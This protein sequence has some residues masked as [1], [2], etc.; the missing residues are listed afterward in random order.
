VG[1]E[2]DQLSQPIPMIS[3]QG[4]CKSIRNGS[5]TVDILKGLDFAVPQGQFAAVTGASGSGKST[6]LG[7]LAGLDTPSAGNVHLNGIAISYLPEDKLAQV[8]GKTIGFV[9][10]SYQLIPT[11]TALENVLLPHELNADSRE[12]GLAR[13]RE[14]LRSVGLEDRMDHY[15]VQL[16]GGEQQRVALAR[17]F[18]LRPPIVLADE[19]TGNLDTTNGAHVLELLL[20]LNRTEGTTLV[21]VTHDPLLAGYADRRIV[22]RDGLIVSDEIN[23]NPA[24]AAPH[25]AALTEG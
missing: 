17:A 18:I 14:L 16:S 25:E 1:K 2:Y 22:L 5:R 6:L 10:Q 4:L 21:L 19:P 20:N 7:L 24:M 9:F 3:V 23:P 15:P 12:S 11:L 8:R 13:A